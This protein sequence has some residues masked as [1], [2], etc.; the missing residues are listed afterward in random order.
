M[1]KFP[2]SPLWIGTQGAW[3][4]SLHLVAPA[5]KSENGPNSPVEVT[6]IS[7]ESKEGVALKGIRI[8]SPSTNALAL[9]KEKGPIRNAPDGWL[10]PIISAYLA[11]PNLNASELA[12][13]LESRTYRNVLTGHL[14]AYRFMDLLIAKHSLKENPISAKGLSL[15]YSLP[16]KGKE[17]ITE[18]TSRIYKELQEWGE[19]T[20]AWLIAQ[21][22]GVAVNTIYGRLNE[23][24]KKELLTKP[25][26]GVR[27][28]PR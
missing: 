26:K 25:G 20:P 18:T 4:A 10:E 19:S 7:H 17:S 11:V 27:K 15:R 9:A 3:A 16:A 2:V 12:P 6:V 5:K 1:A 22:E 23:C 21:I 28:S 24:R 14:L 8:Q 13:H